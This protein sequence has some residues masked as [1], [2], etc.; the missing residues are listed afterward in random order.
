MITRC[1]RVKGQ[2]SVKGYFSLDHS[3]STVSI[4]A[5]PLVLSR[6]YRQGEYLNLIGYF[7]RVPLVGPLFCSID[8]CASTNFQR[9]F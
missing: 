3:H 2:V 8:P 5:T 9:V 6:L 7:C 1:T 4:G